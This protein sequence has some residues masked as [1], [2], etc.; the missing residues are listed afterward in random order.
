MPP[1][2]PTNLTAT[3]GDGEVTLSFTPSPGATSHRLYFSNQANISRTTGTL[4]GTVTSPTL[5]QGL[6]NGVTWYYVVTAVNAAGE[7]AESSVAS[8]IPSSTAGQTNPQV[9]ARRPL[10]G[11][12]GVRVGARVEA[13]FNRELD[14]TTVTAM[15]VG[16]ARLDGGSVAGST[17]AA[18]T[19]LALTPAL[20]LAFE[21]TYQVT[22]GT[23]LRDTLNQPLA[24]TDTWTFTTSSPPPSVTPQ[25]GNGSA[26]LTWTAV[27]G[28]VHYVLTRT[29]V[30]FAAVEWPVSG[31]TFTD[32]SLSNGLVYTYSAAAV[33]TFGRSAPSAD[34]SVTPQP[35]RP[36]APSNFTVVGGRSTALLTWNPVGGATGYSIY[37]AP[38]AGGPYT[39]V[40]TAYQG[41]TWLDTN[42]APDTVWSWVV[43]AESATGTGAWS[44]PTAIRTAGSRLPAPSV[45][46]TA[47]TSWVRLNWTAVPGAVG[48]VIFR[49]TWPNADPVRLGA[50]ATL[51]FDDTS[52]LNGQTYRYF[53]GAVDGE[54]LVGDVTEATASPVPGLVPPPPTMFWPQIEVNRVQVSAQTV[55]GGATLDYFRSSSPDGGF[56]PVPAIEILDGGTT[57]YYAAR[58]TVAGV[59]SELSLPVEVTPAIAATP[60]MPQN[61]VAFVASGW[62]DVLFDPVPN[63]T[64]YQVGLATSPGGTP[65][66]RCTASD[67]WENRCLV[68]LTDNL[69]VYLS[70]RALNGTTPGPWSAEVMVR[71]TNIGPNAGLASPN[72]GVTPGNG[73]TTVSW[74]HVP[75]ASEY[76]VYRRTRRSGWALLTTTP[77]LSV[78][79]LAV[80]NGTDYRY[81]LV[82]TNGTTRFAPTQLSSF[83]RPSHLNPLRPANVT[84]TPTNGGAL[85]RWGAVAGA[86]SYTVRASFFP[87]GGASEFSASCNSPE[88]WRTDCQLPLPNGTSFFV[89]LIAFGAGSLASA[90]TDSIEVTPAPAAPAAPAGLV[91]NAANERLVL[92]ATTTPGGSWRLWRRTRDTAWSD[93]G[94]LPSPFFQDSQPNGVA[95]Q[96][97]LQFITGQG[98]SPLAV[99]NFVRPS[100]LAPLPPTLLEVAPDDSGAWVWWTPVP[101]VSQYQVFTAPA[102]EG[103]YALGLTVNSPRDT[104]GRLSSLTN[105]TPVW[106]AV[107]SLSSGFSSARSNELT[108][109]PSATAL[110]APT[111]SAINGNQAVQLSWPAV[112]GAIS[113]QV[114]RRQDEGAWT[115]AASVTSRRFTDLDVE[116]GERWQYQVRAV[117]AVRTGPGTATA[118]Q[119]VLATIPT[120]PT[121]VTVRAANAGLFVEWPPVALATGYTVSLSAEADGTRNTVCS[122]TSQWETR[123]FATT[124]AARFVFVQATAGASS[125]VTSTPIAGTPNPALP[126]RGA[127][128]TV[129]PGAVGS[130]QVSWANQ[131]G[132]TSY[133]VFRR[134]SNG[135][136]TQVHQS[137]TTTP[138]VDTGLTS[139]QTYVY[140]VEVENSV[141]R[142][143]W[144]DPRSATA[145]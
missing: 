78:N 89:Q 144:S 126:S 76:R 125:S 25:A 44:E 95:F 135:A 62:A 132:A 68:S 121:G 102:P 100:Y 75:G 55:V 65:T 21:T 10:V 117:D 4:L 118:L 3:P 107:T 85:V 103:P 15:N 29:R 64:Q 6:M 134:P 128:L 48:Y 145:P 87:G 34:V 122:F 140:Y 73:L 123:C 38:N 101:G 93:L 8:A 133:R 81:A 129:T 13:R 36:S 61:V 92:R 51:S 47:G 86:N 41:T 88:T 111:V 31:T 120:A 43:Q 71:P 28:A 70:V 104:T 53:V 40:E 49:G 67:T 119:D 52:V 139:G 110:V 50:L 54:Q 99:S 46:A 23:G 79:D 131:A 106:V 66:T 97:A 27:P 114:L 56:V 77:N 108:V 57:W 127:V 109:R 138:F 96:Y 18:G 5:H 2:A 82:A 124:T 14:G 63:A 59:S 113:Y 20:P 1:P 84:V 130:L 19:A 143:A 60:A 90:W 83:E 115:V 35:S 16:L 91:V 32:T 26:T 11:A 12:T 22:L 69:T 9:L 105:G 37:R 39:R 72:I 7:S 17:S 42:L 45:T 74:T 58:V 94:L 142:G 141:G 137:M 33:T 116:N 98:A 80:V 136:A 24:A 30:P 112:T